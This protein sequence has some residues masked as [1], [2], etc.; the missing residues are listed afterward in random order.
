[1][2]YA[3]ERQK[4]IKENPFYPYRFVVLCPKCRNPFVGSASTGKSGKKYA[5][6]HCSRKHQS[7]RIPRENFHSTIETFIS[8]LRFQNSFVDLFEA[9]VMDVWRMKQEEKVTESIESEKN[10]L[11]LHEEQK[12]LLSDYR[13]TESKTVKKLIEEEMEALDK[14]MEGATS[15]RNRNEIT[16]R[17]IAEYLKRARNMVEHPSELLLNASN[18]RLLKQYWGFVFE[19]LP[20]YQELIDGTPRLQMLFEFAQEKANRDIRD[21]S[22]QMAGSSGFEPELTVL[23]TAVLPL[24]P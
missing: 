1:M 22:V 9:V 21:F 8:K 7:V 13:Q 12:K 23:E 6:Y 14:Q 4:K 17:Q 18:Q 24:T 5:A 20:T 15:V 10:V 3:H 2:V 19:E 16:E 11:Q